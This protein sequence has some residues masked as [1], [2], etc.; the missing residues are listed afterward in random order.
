M[1]VEL[2]HSKA[3][4]TGVQHEI[5]EKETNYVGPLLDHGKKFGFYSNVGRQFPCVLCFHI[6]YLCSGLSF[7]G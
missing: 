1:A 7:Q 3:K 4:E 5:E 2:E 6:D